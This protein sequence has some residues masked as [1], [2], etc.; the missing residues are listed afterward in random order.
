MKTVKLKPYLKDLIE[1]VDDPEVREA[2]RAAATS[3]TDGWLVKV[4]EYIVMLQ[5]SLRSGI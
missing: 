4:T 1:R 5:E 3:L 2:L